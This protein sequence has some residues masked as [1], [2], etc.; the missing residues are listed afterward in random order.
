MSIRTSAYLGLLVL[1]AGCSRTLTTA[2]PAES[3]A[4]AGDPARLS[5]HVTIE[6][7]TPALPFGHDWRTDWR[8]HTVPYAE[9]SVGNPRRDGIPPLD[10]PQ[11]VP[12][13]QVDWLAAAE[14][15]VLV[16]LAGLARAYPLQ[17]LMWHE[18]VN[19]TLG[20]TPVAVT[21]CPLCNTALAFD[22]RVAGQALT[23]GVSGLLR[24]S[25][26]VM[27]D[28]QTESLWQQASGAAIVGTLAGAELTLLPATQIAWHVAREQYPQLEVLSRDT[29][30]QRDYGHNPYAGYDSSQRPFLFNGQLDQRL[31]AMQRIVGVR[32]DATAVAYPFEQLAQRRVIRDTIAGQ[33]VV[34]LYA[35]GLRSALDQASIARSADV[36]S[37]TAWRP[38]ANGQP[39]TLEW[40]DGAIRDRETNSVWSVSGHALTGPLAGAQLEPL[41]HANHFWFAWAALACAGVAECRIWQP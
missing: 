7:A 14:P 12:A 16:E 33:P 6:P 2:Q 38:L 39:L 27:W 1:L 21:F 24:H 20:T 32:I 15:V 28:R 25:D 40:R 4:P 10:Q 9:L 26:L 31:P 8:R 5:P 22:R 13:A 29:G 34:I 41:V 36:G 19:D 35:P 37:G 11:F 3:A 30:F 17:I 23:F 18:I